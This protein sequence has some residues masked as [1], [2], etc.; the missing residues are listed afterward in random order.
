MSKSSPGAKRPAG[1]RPPSLRVHSRGQF[2]CR[3]AG[4]DHYFGT[5]REKAQALYHA[6]LRQWG[7][8][9]ETK[10]KRL[11][12]VRTAKIRF[13][14]LVEIFRDAKAADV[15]DDMMRYY[16]NHLRRAINAWGKFP[17]SA[18]NAQHLQALKQDLT[19][20]ELSPVTI[21]HELGAVKS[22]LQWGMNF[23]HIPP[24]NLGA[25]KPPRMPLP[26]EKGMSI[27]AVKTMISTAAKADPRLE[28][29]LAVCYLA[30]CRP[31]ELPRLASKEGRFTART[32]DGGGV[33]A[34]EAKTTWQT[35]EP[36]H[37]ILSPEAMIYF[38]SMKPHWE[39]WES[40]SSRVR[41]PDVCG[42][43]GPH[44]LRHS[45]MTHLLEAGVAREK[46]DQVLGHNLPP[47]VSRTYGPIEW[48]ALVSIAAKLTLR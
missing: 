33:Y 7:E 42:S 35:G 34:I 15:T 11:S 18:I 25:V 46:A 48:T 3:W 24:V 29:W 45:A 40:F 43:G 20:L 22:V 4:V 31:S 19:K 39:N 37:V 47:R 44:P 23:N 21:R 27:E 14:E 32:K 30:A 38:N 12:T 26:K 28:P 36:R 16:K 8:W 10:Q 5:D 41:R 6:S 17:A 1:T 9:I 2:F 13:A